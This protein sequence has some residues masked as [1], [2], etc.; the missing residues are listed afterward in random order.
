MLSSKGRIRSPTF[1]CTPRRS[2]R[3]KDVSRKHATGPDETTF[4]AKTQRS[5][6]KTCRKKQLR[7][8]SRKGVAPQHVEFCFCRILLCDLCAFARNVFRPV[9]SSRCEKRPVLVW[10]RLGRAAQRKTS[11][12][13][14]HHYCSLIL[15]PYLPMMSEA[16]R[17]AV[18]GRATTLMTG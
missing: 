17:G 11:Q 13:L 15:Q 3:G 14:L 6:R 10:L 5:Q 12:A 4:L 1:N 7:V 2:R 16:G 8:A 18:E 9:W